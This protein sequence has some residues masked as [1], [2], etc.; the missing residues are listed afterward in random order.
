[1]PQTVRRAASFWASASIF[2][3][4]AS[5]ITV[6]A[7]VVCIALF[8]LLN[9]EKIKLA[10]SG[11][12]DLAT[13]V[14]RQNA[15]AISG[16]VRFRKADD[17]ETTLTAMIDSV[18]ARGLGAAAFSADGT[19]LVTKGSM[20][21]D[22]ALAQRAMSE[23]AVM[24]SSDGL[25]IASPIV[26]SQG[27][28]PVGALVTAWTLDPIKADL[29]RSLASDIAI[30]AALLAFMIVGSLMILRRAVTQPLEDVRKSLRDVASGAYD[31]PLL[32]LERGDEIGQFCRDLSE[33]RE[34]LTDAKHA[35][36]A[37]EAARSEQ[38]AVVKT[39]SQCLARC[40]EGDFTTRISTPFPDDYEALRHDV[41]QTADA[42]SDVLGGVTDLSLQIRDGVATLSSDASDL[43]RRSE[44]QAA[45]LEETAAA[46]EQLTQSVRHT[47]SG[48]REISRVADDARTEAEV[49]GRIV[50]ETFDAM[51]QIETS[52]S[53]IA[54]IIGVIED[55]AFQTNLLALN[56]G[57]EAARAGEAGLGFAVVASEVRAL[58]QRSSDAAKEIKT[59]ISSS[60][61]HVSDGAAL[62]S[63]AGDALTSIV[64]RVNDIAGEI[65]KMAA[66]VEEQ[67]AGIGEINSGV[68]HLDQLTQQNAGMAG[69]TADASQFLRKNA[70]E[71]GQMVA[72]FS[73]A[74]SS[75]EVE[76]TRRAG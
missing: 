55:I 47:A 40:A 1:M 44:S 63:Q 70:E 4:I 62:V 17:V 38:D 69:Q 49:S 11:L 10:E 27:G 26:S 39:L 9:R 25:R 60:T 34:R 28:A 32:H 71:L 66:T 57:V 54:K 75:A 33:L 67:S 61:Q 12:R 8:S 15:A 59:L 5:L 42:L 3:K 72:R 29:R 30:S 37:R 21:D 53:Q 76:R 13:E 36:A 43:S 45:T 2:T 18:G 41:N 51:G 6:S 31:G 20:A 16:A 23:G 50:R 65:A 19:A 14:T 74:T 22:R 48:A 46:L 64:D 68:S 58:A 35:D 73:L 56:A 52:S 24:W 7:A